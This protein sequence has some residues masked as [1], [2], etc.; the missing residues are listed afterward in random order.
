[1]TLMSSLGLLTGTRDLY[2]EGCLLTIES[3]QSITST[4]VTVSSFLHGIPPT[5]DV[6]IEMG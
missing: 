3:L 6:G 2:D 1:M 4:T 5:H